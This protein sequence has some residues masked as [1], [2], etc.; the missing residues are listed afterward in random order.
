MTDHNGD[1][2]TPAVQIA[3][4]DIGPGNPC[5]IIAEAGVNHNGDVD[6]AHALVDVAGDAG[7]DAVKF[8]TFDPALLVSRDAPAAPY[9][10]AATGATTQQAMLRALALPTR[11]WSSLMSHARDRGLVFLSTAFD[12]PSADLLDKLGVPAFKV[13]SGELNNLD[14]VVDLA[15]RGRPLIISTGMATLA[16]VRSAVSAGSGAHGVCILHCVTAYP[17]SPESANLRAIR[18]LVE[19]F[20]VPVGWSDH[21]VGF[22]TAVA[23]VALGATMLEKH[24]TTDRKLPGPDHAA[25]ANPAEFADYVAAV[26]EAEAALG[27]GEKVPAEEEE[28]NRIFAR[29]SLHAARDLE[30]GHVM[31]AEDVLALRPATGIPP[32]RRVDGLVLKRPVQAGHPIMAQDVN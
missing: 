27:H 13:P 32:D 25:S 16:E 17:A 19:E 14:L 9:Q 12:R 23:S 4:R 1:S 11:A 26:R 24:V 28:S 15:R 30:A 2:T 6:L 5:F 31:R 22:V 3:N 20:H 18:T 29:R 10:A 21:T 7:A 8:Q